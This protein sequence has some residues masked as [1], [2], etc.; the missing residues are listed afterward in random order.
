LELFVS[1]TG[2]AALVIVICVPLNEQVSGIPLQPDNVSSGSSVKVP[3]TE[4]VPEV[5]VVVAVTTTGVALLTTPAVTVKVLEVAPWATVTVAGKGETEGL[6]LTLT[7][8][9]PVGAIPV[10]VIVP[11]VIW[12]EATFMGLKVSGFVTTGGITVRPPPVPVPLGSVA[13]MVTA[14]LL[15]TGF[16]LT[17]NV[18]VLARPA[19]LKVPLVGAATPGLLLITVTVKPAAG[20]G[21]FRT[22]VPVEL[23]PPGP[24]P[25]VTGLGLNVNIEM[26]AGL[27]V[28]VPLALLAA[29]VAMTVTT[30]CAATP[31]VVA[32]N[33]WDFVPAK[34]VTLA[35]T[36]IGD[37]P[38]GTTLA[39]LMETTIP[40]AWA[41]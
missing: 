7:I 21:P 10:S 24:V 17:V 4:F 30:V 33:V 39:M 13:V 14:V 3:I 2:I 5:V 29:S 38:A 16:V 12:L 8:V 25:P 23:T 9:P 26:T 11:V 6:L 41:F 1:V 15:A 32:V 20:A 36:V 34:I 18:P 22:T 19:M 35:G 27:T 37:A 28:N 31:T 40:P